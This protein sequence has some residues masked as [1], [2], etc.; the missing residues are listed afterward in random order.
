MFKKLL[1]S[2]DN[3]INIEEILKENKRLQAKVREFEEKEEDAKEK[4]ALLRTEFALFNKMKT[5]F[6]NTVQALGLKKE[7]LGDF[8]TDMI[9]SETD[10]K[11]IIK[12]RAAQTRNQEKKVEKELVDFADTYAT[13][14]FDHD[15]EILSK[16]LHKKVLDFK[17]GKFIAK[18]SVILLSKNLA[19]SD[20]FIIVIDNINL[21]NYTAD[22]IR[23]DE[24]DEWNEE[25]V[26]RGW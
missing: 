18:N 20:Q 8:A 3:N 14:Y 1:A 12:K 21:E 4:E 2:K 15:I 7:E 25:R 23:F 24:Q 6:K 19:D 16:E 10:P 9:A 22:I 13:E 26:N 11:E 5:D 17:T